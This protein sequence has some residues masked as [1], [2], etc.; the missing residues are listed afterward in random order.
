[1]NSDGLGF[2]DRGR[3]IVI[4]D[5]RDES[6]TLAA[7][8]LSATKWGSFQVTGNDEY[9]AMCVKLAAQH[10]FKINNPE[11][12]NGIQAQRDLHR[13]EQ[14]RKE[15]AQQAE[16]AAQQP[17]IEHDVPPVERERPRGRG[18]FEIG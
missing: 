8:Q 9:K 4:G 14:Q 6:V 10:G 12:Q 7:L 5:W 3:N 13:Q 2:V 17:V 1:M 18:G 15:A 16:K 11:L